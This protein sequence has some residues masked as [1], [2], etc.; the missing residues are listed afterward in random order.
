MAESSADM[1]LPLSGKG[2][3]MRLLYALMR[4]EPVASEAN[5]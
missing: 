1:A 2:G 4:E 3:R 5:Q